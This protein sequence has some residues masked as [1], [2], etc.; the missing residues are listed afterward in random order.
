M[1][2]RPTAL[3]RPTALQVL[4]SRIRVHAQG[5]PGAF[6]VGGGLVAGAVTALLA[7]LSSTPGLADPTSAPGWLLASILTATLVVAALCGLLLFF[8]ARSLPKVSETDPV[9]YATARLQ[10]AS[11]ELGPDPETNRLARQLADRLERRS[12]PHHHLAPLFVIMVFVTFRPLAEVIGPD[13]EPLTLFQLT[14]TVLFLLLI[15]PAYLGARARYSRIAAF[16]SS[17]D[18]ARS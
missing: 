12:D 15:V 5:H 14:P 13:F 9:R 2:A 4:G 8:E 6:A 7:L 18:A 1:N 10:A 11:G 17:Y 16:R 3:P